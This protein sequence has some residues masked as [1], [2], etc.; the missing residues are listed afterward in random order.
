MTKLTIF[1]RRSR[2]VVTIVDCSTSAIFS[3][4]ATFV[5]IVTV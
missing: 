5:A 2:G 3:I 4:M 1:K